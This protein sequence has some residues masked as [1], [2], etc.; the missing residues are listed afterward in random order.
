MPKRQVEI[1]DAIRNQMSVR[2]IEEH[3]IEKVVNDP[4]QS[5]VVRRRGQPIDGRWLYRGSPSPGR[6]LE[7]ECQIRADTGLYRIVRVTQV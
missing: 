6:I 7:I 2:L 5:I 1:D 3:E 4:K